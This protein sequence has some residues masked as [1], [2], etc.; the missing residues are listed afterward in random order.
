MRV[1][2]KIMEAILSVQHRPCWRLP[3]EG[4][5]EQILMGRLRFPLGRK[6]RAAG[7]R[8]KKRESIPGRHDAPWVPTGFPLVE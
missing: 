1:E 4:E 8:T 3:E 5:S 6:V 2:R 7:K